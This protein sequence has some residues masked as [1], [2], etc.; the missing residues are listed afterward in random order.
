MGFHERT[1]IALNWTEAVPPVKVM[2]F[3]LTTMTGE[4]CC[5]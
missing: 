4:S 2:Y 3:V 1:D 5:R